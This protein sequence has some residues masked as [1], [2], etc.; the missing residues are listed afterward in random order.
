MGFHNESQSCDLL[1]PL[2]TDGTEKGC[3][4]WLTEGRPVC[5]LIRHINWLQGATL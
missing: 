5:F 1:L 2:L 3:S 4:L